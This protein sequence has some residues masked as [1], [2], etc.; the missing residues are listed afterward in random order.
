[1]FDFYDGVKIIKDKTSK[2]IAI[3][4]RFSDGSKQYYYLKE[5]DKKWFE[6]FARHVLSENA[7]SRKERYHSEFSLDDCPY[8]GATFID[9]SQNPALN[10]NNQEE[11]K[12][13]FLFY[14]SLTKIQKRRLRYK[15]ENPKITFQ[16]IAEKE[17]TTRMAIFKSF[18]QIRKNYNAFTERQ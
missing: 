18:V 17:K 11:K 16:A 8:E 9:Y 6:E 5:E 10:L 4:W 12:T 15:L 14:K 13:L 1:M 2:P 7:L 3:E